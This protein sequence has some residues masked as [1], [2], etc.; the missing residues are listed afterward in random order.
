MH[1][2]ALAAVLI[3]RVVKAVDH[4]HGAGEGIGEGGRQ[5]DADVRE[6]LVP[7]PEQT[8]SVIPVQVRFGDFQTG[9]GAEQTGIELGAVVPL[10][11]AIGLLEV[12]DVFE[13]P[14]LQAVTEQAAPE[15][16][17]MSVWTPTGESPLASTVNLAWL[18]PKPRELGFV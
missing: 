5:L 2:V 3:E 12:D 15:P 17:Q 8:A 18:R 1:A 4:H 16:N 14:G 9:D 13:R 7:G 10:V 11:V 6:G